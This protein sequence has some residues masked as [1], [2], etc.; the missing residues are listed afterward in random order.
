M[1]I[2]IKDIVSNLKKAIIRFPLSM[3]IAS[4]ATLAALGMV[5]RHS[6]EDNFLFGF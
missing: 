1:K 3:G 6:T 4:V 2:N 5:A